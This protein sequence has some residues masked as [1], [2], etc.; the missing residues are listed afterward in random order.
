M[1]KLWYRNG[2]PSGFFFGTMCDFGFALF[3][4]LLFWKD[5]LRRRCSLACREIFLRIF[6]T[7]LEDLIYS[8][9]S[10][11]NNLGGIFL[12]IFCWEHIFC[13]CQTVMRVL[14]SMGVYHWSWSESGALWRIKKGILFGPD[15]PIH[16]RVDQCCAGTWI[17]VLKLKVLGTCIKNLTWQDLN[18]KNSI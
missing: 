11:L 9:L 16:V 5:D 7:K 15:D 14:I 6:V 4:D 3:L 12:I 17:Q 1:W 18:I 8:V 2:K 10:L 13:V